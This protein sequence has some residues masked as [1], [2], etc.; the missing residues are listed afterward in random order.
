[1]ATDYKKKKCSSKKRF[2]N[3]VLAQAALKKINP[4]KAANKPRRAYK[5]TVC[6]GFHLT[7]N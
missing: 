5:C 2:A 3:D 7:S 1:M 4:N 6:A